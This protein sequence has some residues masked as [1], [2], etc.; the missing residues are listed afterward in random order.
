MFKDV[1]IFVSGFLNNMR[2]GFVNYKHVRFHISSLFLLTL[3]QRA[4]VGTR[5]LLS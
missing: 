1:V 5:E 2:N 4:T 3:F